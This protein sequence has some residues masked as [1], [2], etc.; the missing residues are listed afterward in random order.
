MEANRA[1]INT[2]LYS[3]IFDFPLTSE[4]IWFYLS[5]N[6]YIPRE[7]FETALKLKSGFEKKGSYYYLT[8][9][10]E[11]VEHR[12]LKEK[13]S[14]KQL[15]MAKKVLGILSKIP[16]VRLVGI[17]GSLALS[18][19]EVSDDIDVFIITE[20]NSL[21]LTRFLAGTMLILQ[22]KYRWKNDKE[23]ANKF[24]L[25]MLI[26]DGFIFPK[27]KQ[28]LY[29]AHEIAQLLPLY[30][31]K[32]AYSNFLKTNAWILRFMPNVG[33]KKIQKVSTGIVGKLGEFLLRVLFAEVLFEFIQKQYM[34]AITK[35]TLEKNI[36]AFHPNDYRQEILKRYKTVKK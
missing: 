26:S 7:D 30:E 19:S 2:L 36:L 33:Q 5:S 13:N 1:V 4:E 29:I 21:W 3:D 14:K 15:K 25:N 28:D 17:S 18:A 9:R 31:R 11:L 6:K 10:G 32:N 23:P 22:R 12:K 8:G 16:T 20:K 27:E 24:C 34:G 35:E